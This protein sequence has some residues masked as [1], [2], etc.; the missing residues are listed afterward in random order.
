MV[1]QQENTWTK[2]IEENNSKSKLLLM[3]Q[4]LEGS[5]PTEG[6]YYIV[7]DD[8]GGTLTVGHGVTL[9]YQKAKLE[10][11]GIDVDSLEKGSKVPKSAVD[12]VELKNITARRENI[13]NKLN[14]NNIKLEDYQIDALAIRSYN[15]GNIDGFVDAYKEYGNTED[16]YDK[17]MSTPN[18]VNGEYWLGL[19]KRRQAEWKLFHEGIY[20]IK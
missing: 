9:T 16:L 15:V 17:Y 6:D 14:D 18:K 3:L 11:E 7:Y 8:G 2:S 20:T 5:G 19:D 4:S 10:A 12:A 13:L 1:H